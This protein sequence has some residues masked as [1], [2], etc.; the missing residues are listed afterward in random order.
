[1]WESREEPIENKIV[2]NKSKRKPKQKRRKVNKN[3]DKLFLCT[4]EILC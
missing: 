3:F 2:I 1:M 4:R